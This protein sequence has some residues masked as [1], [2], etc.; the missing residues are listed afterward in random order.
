MWLC[1][2][3]NMALFVWAIQLSNN[4]RHGWDYLLVHPMAQRRNVGE[5]CP[6]HYCLVL[7]QKFCT[8]TS[9]I[10][11]LYMSSYAQSM[12]EKPYSTLPYLTKS[13]SFSHRSHGCCCPLT[14]YISHMPSLSHD[15]FT[16]IS[17]PPLPLSC[18]ESHQRVHT[19]VAKLSKRKPQ[20]GLQLMLLFR[21]SVHW[22]I[23]LWPDLFERMDALA[24]SNPHFSNK[25]AWAR[26]HPLVVSGLECASYE[27]IVEAD[28]E[29]RLL[30]C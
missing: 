26:M 3:F 1:S 25:S 2:A 21:K 17:H 22:H 18:F 29:A 28:P 13:V 16:A 5:T 14:I 30:C 23:K 8:V 24:S 15:P 27:W 12:H 6:K 11:D 20:P 10:K 7:A 4:Q 9:L 19:Q